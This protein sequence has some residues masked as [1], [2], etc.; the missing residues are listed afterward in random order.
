M[1][2]AL[3]FLN[4]IFKLNLKKQD[5]EVVWLN[6][7][8][9]TCNGNKDISNT[10]LLLAYLFKNNGIINLLVRNRKR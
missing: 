5:I 9:E 7:E 1:F 10:L 2:T 3:K 6:W 4:Q 8:F